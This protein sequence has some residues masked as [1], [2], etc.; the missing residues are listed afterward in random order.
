MDRCIPVALSAV[1]FEDAVMLRTHSDVK[2][3]LSLVNCIHGVIFIWRK[4]RNENG[5]AFDGLK[6]SIAD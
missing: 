3:L 2:R 1:A 4:E 6:L 5:N